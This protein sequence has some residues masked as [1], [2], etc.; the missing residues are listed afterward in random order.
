MESGEADSGSSEDG[1]SKIQRGLRLRGRK[2]S[3]WR[4]EIV[5]LLG[6]GENIGNVVALVAPGVEVDWREEDAVSAMEDEA[7]ARKILRDAEA[8][9]EVALVRKHQAAGIA[10]LAA[11]KNLRR[12]AGEN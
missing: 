4:S 11:N 10:V 12:A 3:C 1:G 9:S 2:Q 6:L 7:E 8:G 5:E